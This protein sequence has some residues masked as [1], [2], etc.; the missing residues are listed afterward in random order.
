LHRAER[1]RGDLVADDGA[2]ERWLREHPHT[3]AQQLRA[4]IRQARKDARP[5]STPGDAPR[6]GRAYRQIFALVRAS[7]ASDG[8]ATDQ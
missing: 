2:F 7:L 8:T 6:Q 5:E 1:W 3:D 4:L